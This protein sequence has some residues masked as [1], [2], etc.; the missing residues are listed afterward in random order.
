MFT[1]IKLYEQ[2]SELRRFTARVLDCREAENGWAVILNRTAFFPEGG[3]Q[4][5]DEP[6]R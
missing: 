6:G 4:A 2:N 5:G 3:G 1:T